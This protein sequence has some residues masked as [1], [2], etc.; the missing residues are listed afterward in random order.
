MIHNVSPNIA[1][2][3]YS[4]A[5]GQTEKQPRQKLFLADN[6]DYKS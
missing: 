6:W 1:V 5:S 2:G 4:D 3:A